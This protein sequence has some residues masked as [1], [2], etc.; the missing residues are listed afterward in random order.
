M[1]HSLSI[2]EYQLLKAIYDSGG[3]TSTFAVKEFSPDID[4]STIR[5]QLNRIAD[6]GYLKQV[7]I[8]DS[9]REIIPYQVNSKTCKLFQNPNSHLRKKHNINYI[10][11]AL[12]KNHLYFELYK[13]FSEYIITNNTDRISLLIDSIG[14]DNSLL[15]HKFNK[16]T[17]FIHV[18]ELI[19][20]LLESS[21]L[22]LKS[23]TADNLIY[24]EITGKLIFLYIDK[25]EAN[26][27]S[28]L[29]SLINRYKPLL[30]LNKVDISFIVI[31]DSEIRET[32]YKSAIK[33][34]FSNNISPSNRIPGKVIEYHTQVLEKKLGFSHDALTDLNSKVR[35]KYNREFT[36]TDD[37]L[38]IIS[39]DAIK[40]NGIKEINKNVDKIFED[41]NSTLNEKSDKIRLLFSTIYMMYSSGVIAT[42]DELDIKTYRINHI[43]SKL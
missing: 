18:E 11:R 23:K 2:D 1:N 3:Y 40:S 27:T 32:L 8:S 12:I 10:V 21:N 9:L 41:I 7:Q 37:E 13:D 5:K 15:P 4:I 19:L 20:N 24:D 6:K 34:I 31:T 28:Q 16:G 26:P 42:K 22:K 36:L 29:K 14:F 25:Y 38:S 33:R 30:K 35:A 17:G 39:V 43:Y